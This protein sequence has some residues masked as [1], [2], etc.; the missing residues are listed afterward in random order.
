MNRVLFHALS[1]SFLRTS[2]QDASTGLL[3]PSVHIVGTP[4]KGTHRISALASFFDFAD[5][6][7]IPFVFV[8]AACLAL[9]TCHCGGGTFCVHFSLSRERKHSEKN[10]TE[11]LHCT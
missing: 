10:C 8:C 3:F 2:F 6:G 1:N 11:S 5:Y 9:Q 4:F 7:L